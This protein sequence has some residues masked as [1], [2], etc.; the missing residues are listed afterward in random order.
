MLKFKI[1]DFVFY[2]FLFCLIATSC[3]HFSQKKQNPKYSLSGRKILNEYQHLEGTIGSEAFSMELMFTDTL[4]FGTIYDHTNQELRDLTGS[5]FK[6]DSL[7]LFESMTGKFDAKYKYDDF[8][9]YTG[10]YCG[11]SFEGLFE[12]RGKLTP[13]VCETT[14]TN[15]IKFDLLQKK[16]SIKDNK[17]D[18]ILFTS[19]IELIYCKQP[20]YEFIN[21]HLSLILEPTIESPNFKAFVDQLLKIN[22]DTFSKE[23]IL[24]MQETP[25]TLARYSDIC[26]NYNGLL[27]LSATNI[28]FLGGMHEDYLIKYCT[29]DL[30]R[31]KEI[32]I[33]DVLNEQQLRN[34][35]DMLEKK[36]RHKY[37]LSP[38]DNL[39]K[40][41]YFD[42]NRFVNN[43]YYI[44]HKGIGFS[45]NPYEIAGLAQGSI[46][47]YI[48]FD[49]LNNG[50]LKL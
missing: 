42:T 32:L 47:L 48:T 31:K 33:H 22:I 5:Y 14:T 16:D 28:K 29:I 45:Y 36:F 12:S 24:E 37:A 46:S 4:V 2:T 11:G 6:N 40:V 26:Y 18:K 3:N 39:S 10:K 50:N 7:F 49:E 38:T 34:L 13:F 15:F 9:Y 20:Q 8:N 1:K 19:E 41:L 44:T 27:V 23:S 25:Y 43:N 17:L 35:P 21:K 30:N